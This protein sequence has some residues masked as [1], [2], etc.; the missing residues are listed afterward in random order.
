MAALPTGLHTEASLVIDFNTQ[1]LTSLPLSDFLKATGKDADTAFT[2][3]RR[4]V[5]PTL[6]APFDRSE[7]WTQN[8]EGLAHSSTLD[9]RP[10][11]YRETRKS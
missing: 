3:L 9:T 5:G 2:S 4:K 6:V 8:G 7:N 11:T 1:T 10:H